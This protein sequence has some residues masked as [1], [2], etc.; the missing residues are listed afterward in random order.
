MRLGEL[1]VRAGFD[2]FFDGD[3]LVQA[4]HGRPRGVGF[5]RALAPSRGRR[6]GGCGGPDL[7]GT[8]SFGLLVALD[9]SLGVWC[10]S[11]TRRPICPARLRGSERVG[12]GFAMLRAAV[13]LQRMSSLAAPV[14]ST[15]HVADWTGQVHR[16]RDT[17]RRRLRSARVRRAP[18][19]R[20][21]ARSA[22]SAKSCADEQPR[23]PA[24]PW[25]TDRE[26]RQKSVVSSMI[27]SVG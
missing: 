23:R 11:L 2:A 1:G 14:R 10:F 16:A 3:D 4:R 7:R 8:W 12:Q 19:S 22:L 21:P 27:I 15:R 18:P 6:E 25:V 17:A 26:M 24:G 13:D 20:I 9:V 5:W